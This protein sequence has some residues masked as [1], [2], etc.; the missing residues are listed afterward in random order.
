MTALLTL[1]PIAV[2]IEVKFCA[3]ILTDFKDA[4]PDWT[5]TP[6]WDDYLNDNAVARPLRGVRWIASGPGG[7]RSAYSESSGPDAGCGILDLDDNTWAVGM[8]TQGKIGT[9]YVETRV[10]PATPNL[11]SYTWEL[12][13]V[14]VAPYVE[15]YLYTEVGTTAEP[16]NVFTNM[17]WAIHHRDG[18]MSG[19]TYTAWN[20]ACP[21]GGGCYDNANNAI[22][23]GSNQ[24]ERYLVTHELGH[25]LFHM[26][27]GGGSS[28]SALAV[29]GLCIGPDLLDAG[30]HFSERE[31]QSEGFHEGF[32]DFYAALTFNRQNESDCFVHWYKQSDFDQ[33]AD[34]ETF[35]S[36]CNGPPERD[37]F[38]N[39]MNALDVLNP[40]VSGFDYL[41]DCATDLGFG[42]ALFNRST[43]YDWMRGLWD[44]YR[45]GGLTLTKLL[46]VISQGSPSTW[47]GTSDV[48]ADPLVAPNL[49]APTLDSAAGVIEALYGPAGLQSTWAANAATNGIDR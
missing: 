44:L 36:N 9:N 25:L 42:G 32:A 38:G 1:L 12:A 35:T 10:L 47:I 11:Y 45:N 41:T 30:H 29:A 48:D 39:P 40:L 46:D 26:R 21:G 6:M 2:A 14:P 13:Y 7:Y 20:A 8:V 24:V 17:G 15:N 18:G 43:E 3:D 27:T 4:V 16:W 5:E 22:Y 31:W 49:P 19:K 23:R 28:N 33:D 34:L 37:P